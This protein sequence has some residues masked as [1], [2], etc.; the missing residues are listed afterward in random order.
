M[1]VEHQDT[2][3]DRPPR[4]STGDRVGG[5]ADP[6]T[7]REAGDQ[8]RASTADTGTTA[9]LD[10]LAR[11]LAGLARTLQSASSPQDVLDRAVALAVGLVPGA[12]HGGISLVRA[13]RTVTSA[14][15]TAPAA[16]HLD[17]LQTELGQGPCLDAV[18]DQRST[19][20]DDLAGDGRW[21][22][23]AARAEEIGMASMLCLQLFVDGDN[24]G[25]LNLLGTRKEAFTDASEHV[26][27]LLAA[28]TAVAVADARQLEHTQRGLASRDLIGQAKGILM[29]RHKLSAD[30]AF[31][32]LSRLSQ[33]LNRK[34]AD[35]A[36]DFTASGEL[37]TWTR[38]QP[39]TPPR[40]AP[41]P[42]AD[43]R[44]GAQGET[45]APRRDRS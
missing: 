7:R 37:P 32:L 36:A 2:P 42:R 9:G 16:R 43:T 45:H 28:H 1:D 30:Q 24:L 12:E 22:V 41:R 33:D 25:A 40:T 29:E 38:S 5:E 20:V 44:P 15:A 8:G 3:S 11:E 17:Q 26:G 10:V 14:A 35:V 6:P 4:Q 27:L 34:V 21:P 13:R 18:F 19:R 23:L 39:R 31:A